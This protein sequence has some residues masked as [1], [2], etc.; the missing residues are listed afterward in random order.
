MTQLKQ[1]GLS[2]VEL[3]IALALSSL[4]ILGITQVYIDNRSSHLFHQGQSENIENGRYALLVLER[5]LAK[6]GYR[7]R[8][9]E[10][11]ELVFPAENNATIG[12]EFEAGETIARVDEK[13]LC[14]RYQPRASNEYDCVGNLLSASA[15]PYVNTSSDKPVIE[16]ITIV[17]EVMTCNGVELVAGV[18]DIRFDFGVGPA[19][20]REV[21]EYM[22]EPNRPIRSVRYALLMA[23]ERGN[24]QGMDSKA[25]EDWHGNQPADNRLYFSVSNSMT[26]RNM[27]P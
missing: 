10:P 22:T 14:L 7:R 18:S 25:Y 13:T 20:S 11:Y 5:Q 16:R 4:F 9:N 6:T 12:C 24:R 26:L 3:M 15:T 23:S 21:T 27:M 1:T 2:L 19:G 17:D 8:P